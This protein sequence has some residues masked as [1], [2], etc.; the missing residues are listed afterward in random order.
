MNVAPN[1]WQIRIKPRVWYGMATGFGA[2]AAVMTISEPH[3][4]IYFQF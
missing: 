2:A 4:F 3:P 1:T